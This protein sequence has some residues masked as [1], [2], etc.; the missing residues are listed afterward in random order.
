MWRPPAQLVSY[1]GNRQTR[2]QKHY[3]SL[4]EIIANVFCNYNYI[5]LIT[6]IELSVQSQPRGVKFGLDLLRST[7]GS[8]EES[9]LSLCYY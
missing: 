8:V 1:R 9:L 6:V 5:I 7:K 2:R 3:T 4:V